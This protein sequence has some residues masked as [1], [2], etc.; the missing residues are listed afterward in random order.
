MVMAVEMKSSFLYGFIFIPLSN[1]FMDNYIF[2]IISSLRFFMLLTVPII[3][4]FFD[5][6][7]FYI[8]YFLSYCT[9][10]SYLQ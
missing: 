7:S 8:Y 6:K 3:L 5:I 2:Y 9:F 10:L 1:Y 4:K